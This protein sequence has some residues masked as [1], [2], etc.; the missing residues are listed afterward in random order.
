MPNYV[1]KG[2]NRTGLVQEGVL[3]ADTKEVA[4]A[5]LRRQNIVVTGNVSDEEVGNGRGAVMRF[6]G[7]DYVTVRDNVQPAQ[8]NRD[9]YMVGYQRSCKVTS[10]GNNLGPY[11]AG[12]A[13]E[14]DGPYDGCTNMHPLAQ[15]IRPTQFEGQNLKIDVG[16]N[17]GDGVIPCPA[18]NNCGGFY[19]GGA[20]TVL[21]A[22]SGGT[23]AER[24]M[25]QGSL[26]FD[27]PI[28]S[29]T[30]D[31]TLTWIEPTADISD[32]RFQIDTEGGVRLESSF[33]VNRKAG[34]MNKIVRRTYELTIGDGVLDLDLSPGGTGANG[35]ILSFIEINRA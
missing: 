26:K 29:G 12:Q 9:M 30:Y 8:I 23:L 1:W 2:R 6:V 4:L 20:A 14:L 19:K 28:R 34:G 3:A 33:D 25:L 22:A 21:T 27:I 11:G 10:S 24:T 32:R 5:T 16:G 31:L 35:P 18:T 13:K 7:Y 15:A 17:G